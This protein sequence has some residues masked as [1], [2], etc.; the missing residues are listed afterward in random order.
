MIQA[1]AHWG[2]GD[3]PT[4]NDA[5]AAL[6]ATW[7]LVEQLTGIRTWYRTGEKPTRPVGRDD[8][9]ELLAEGVHLSD[10]RPPQTMTELGRHINLWDGNEGD[11]EWSAAVEGTASTWR[12]SALLEHP[13]LPTSAQ[14]AWPILAQMIQ[15][16]QPDTAVSYTHLT[17]PTKRIV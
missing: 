8:L 2:P 16:W 3:G 12:G 1:A 15:I 5:I 17:L 10:D 9:P 14:E 11:A 13:D 7:D 4:G 6:A